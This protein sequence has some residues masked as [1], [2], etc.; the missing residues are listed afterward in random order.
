MR[1]VKLLKVFLPGSLESA[2][3]KITDSPF[4]K[5]ATDGFEP[6]SFNNSSI[7]AKFIEEILSKESI[8]DPFGNTEEVISKRYIVN[9]FSISSIKNEHLLLLENPSRSV[10]GLIRKLSEV[11]GVEFYTSSIEIDIIKLSEFFS[12]TTDAN[13]LKTTRALLSGVNL[14]ESCSANIEITSIN[15][16]IADAKQHFRGKKFKIDRARFTASN[17]TKK[18][19]MEVRS[20][21]LISIYGPDDKKLRTLIELFINETLS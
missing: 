18:S 16:A 9:E 11:L 19:A 8:T 12:K 7:T 6:I 21:G 17:S 10:R 14:D 13:H 2:Y 5:G 20:S 4:K 3:E 15:D 1:K